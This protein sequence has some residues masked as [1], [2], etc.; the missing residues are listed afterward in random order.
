MSHRVEPV[1]GSAIR[2]SG[3]LNRL[4]SLRAAAAVGVFLVHLRQYNVWQL[5]ANLSA[6]GYTGVG[7]FYIL[8][9][10]ILVM[11]SPANDRVAAFYRR[12]F[13][14]VY[15]SSFVMVFVALAVP[16]VADS[17][18]PWE[19]VTSLTLTQSWFPVNNNIVY[20]T[21]AVS[22]SL[23]C[24]AAFYLAF[25]FALA[26]LRG[27]RTHA[28]WTFA[29]AWW[30]VSGILTAVAIASH[31]E[32]ATTAVYVSPL[33]RFSEFAIGIVAALEI[34]EGWRPQIPLA[35][36]FALLLVITLP[37]SNVHIPSPAPDFFFDLPFLALIVGAAVVDLDSRRGWLASRPLIYAGEVSFCF[38]LVH[39]LI[40]VNMLSSIGRGFGAALLLFAISAAAAVALHHVVELPCQRVL[41]GRQRRLPVDELSPAARVR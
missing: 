2:L 35:L 27:R 12:R 28:R 1:V 21:N 4:T 13:A 3:P 23:S 26:W 39:E 33:L 10:F 20:G 14:R 7:F 9:G 38:Y 34:V 5:P 37:V 25:P 11:A 40:I 15:P 17:R 19:I 18:G 8:S 6:N 16:V 22:W 24:E 41:R 36:V 30:V 31:R 29:I 32:F